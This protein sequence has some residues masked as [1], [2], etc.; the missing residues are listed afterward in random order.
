VSDPARVD[1]T[2][3]DR[4][5]WARRQ[6]RLTRK[7]LAN[8]TGISEQALGYYERDER[9]ASGEALEKLVPVLGVT[10]DFLLGLKGTPRYLRGKSTAHKPYKRKI[11]KPTQSPS[12]TLAR[13][14][15]G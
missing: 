7:E 15:G 14:L 1:L 2:K 3:G 6:M 4:L 10:S 12:V 11:T 9:V 5:R 8:A 13:P